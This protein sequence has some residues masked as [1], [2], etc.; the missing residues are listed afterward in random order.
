MSQD[1]T[2]FKFKH[3]FY[4]P[5]LIGYMRLILLYIC[6]K[7]RK[8]KL[9]CFLS[10]ACS[11][12]LDLFDGYYARKLNQSTKFGYYL[13]MICDRLSTTVSLII[14]KFNVVYIINDLVSHLIV[15]YDSYI[16]KEH[17]KNIIPPNLIAKLYLKSNIASGDINGFT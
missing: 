8:N 9:I 5:N 13:D 4:I 16:T 1:Q 11:Y 14:N 15:L 2:H 6:I 7:K 17:Q 12:F 10:Y 3:L